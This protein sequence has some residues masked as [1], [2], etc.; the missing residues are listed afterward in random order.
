FLPKRS[1]MAKVLFAVVALVVLGIGSMG[2]YGHYVASEDEGSKP[3]LERS[4]DPPASAAARGDEK[5]PHAAEGE[6]AAKDRE[7]AGNGEP[8]DDEPKPGAAEPEPSRAAGA[9]AP[10]A[11]ARPRA[12]PVKRAPQRPAPSAAAPAPA[13]PEP[14]APAPPPPAPPKGSD[15]DYGF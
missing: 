12:A 5:T 4:S 11:P 7:P 8:G 3:P 9:P 10:A 6:T 13:A 14:A 15:R 2:V 1:W